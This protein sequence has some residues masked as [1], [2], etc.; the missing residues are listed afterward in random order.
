MTKTLLIYSPLS[1]V[2]L[3]LKVE[4]HQEEFDILLGDSFSDEELEA[5]EAT[6]ETIASIEVQ[7][8]L[9]E[10]T[11]DDLVANPE[12]E[13]RQRAFFKTCRSC[14]CL[15]HLP[16]L[17]NNPFQVT[18]LI[19]L[20]WTL[21]DVLIDQGGMEELVFKKTYLTELKRFKTMEVLLPKEK[22]VLPQSLGPV[23]QLFMDVYR[24]VDRL[25]AAE[26]SAGERPEKLIE[27]YNLVLRGKT[28][29]TTL[30]RQSGLNPKDFGDRLESLKFFLKKH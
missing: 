5:H 3:A 7:P 26:I 19:D 22:P 29:A 9:E 20:L 6:L 10:L 4:A 21:D 18:Y 13:E 12:D 27:L 23:D 15:E 2:D 24:E 17:E 25:K 28:D 30:L 16:Y 11:F 14:I 8:I 1:V